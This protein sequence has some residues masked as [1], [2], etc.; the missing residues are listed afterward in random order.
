MSRRTITSGAGCVFIALI[1]LTPVAG[2]SRS[3]QTP[4]AGIPNR[5]G[6]YAGCYLN[7]TGA[8]RLI[9]TARR[10]RANETRATWSRRGRPGLAGPVGPAGVQGPQGAQGLQGAQGAQGE[11]GA[12]GPAGPAGPAGADGPQGDPG[13]VGPQG[14]TGLDGPQGSPGPQG[15][16]G[17]PGPQGATGATGPAGPSDSQV[18]APVAMTS[19]AGANA[20]TV[21]SAVATCPASKTILGGGASY[22]LSNAAQTNR[23]SLLTSSPSAADA[24]TVTARVNQNLGGTVTVTVSAYAVCTV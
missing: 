13:A 7:G 14:P 3:A 20:G 15:P 8:L 2:G 18:L 5:A 11:R 1:V 12:Q 21:I 16:Q 23:V 24:W 19:T 17:P 10:C 4:G 9:S 22:S 6:V